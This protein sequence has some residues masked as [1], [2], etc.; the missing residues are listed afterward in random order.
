MARI[1]VKSNYIIRAT[2]VEE[3]FIHEQSIEAINE[4]TVNPRFL[5]GVLNSKV[6]SYYAINE[7]DF[8]QRNTFLKMRLTQIKKFPIPNSTKEQ[9]DSIAILVEQLMDEMN[10]PFV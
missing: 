3:N 6:L 5:I 4:I 10:E 9:Q 7:F 2:L 8:L 1:P